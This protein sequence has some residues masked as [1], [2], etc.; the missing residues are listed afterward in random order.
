VK[1]APAWYEERH[2]QQRKAHPSRHIRVDHAIA[3]LKN[4]GALAPHHGR[5]EYNIVQAVAGLLSHQQTA[6]LSRS[7]RA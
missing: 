5:R 7:R 6:P 3:N 1:N 4:W 2:E